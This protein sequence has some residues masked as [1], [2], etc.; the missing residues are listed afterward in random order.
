[1]TGYTASER[2]ALKN[3]V[4]TTLSNLKSA[5]PLEKRISCATQE[6]RLSYVRVLAAWL[7]GETP[8]PSMLSQDMLRILRDLDAVVTDSSGLSCYP[9]SARDRGIRVKYG[10]H[11]A[12]AM[13][14]IDAL[15]VARIA[16][17]ATQISATCNHCLQPV[18]CEVQ[19]D[20]SLDHSQTD[21]ARVVWNRT[22]GAAGSCSDNLCRNLNF[23]CRH[24]R[25]PADATSLTL[26]QAT[27]VANA[28]FA[29]QQRLL[30]ATSADQ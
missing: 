11:A 15:A 1:M 6:T 3:A 22:L 12:Q 23:Q 17:T 26:P 18:T 24:C 5:F 27:A 7:R 4:L 21:N 8:L 29:F 2:T 16:R 14:A 25:I 13:C 19:A 28:F 10:Q 20:G 30:Q 9:F